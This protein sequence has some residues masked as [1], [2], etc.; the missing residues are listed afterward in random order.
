MA[1]PKGGL[2]RGLSSLLPDYEDY[3]E[4]SAEKTGE[5]VQELK[6]EDIMPNPDQPRKH[7]DEDK[8]TDLAESIKEN[9]VLQP[10]LVVPRENGKYMIVAGERRWRAS[11]MAGKETI[12]A[13]IKDASLQ[14]VLELALIENVQRDDLSPIEEA[15]AYSL[16]MS[17]FDYTQEKLSQRMGKSRSAIANSTRLLDLPDDVL[18]MVEDGKLT[19]GHV[20]PLLGINVPEWQSFIAHEVYQAN[21]TVREVEE[22]VQKAQK[23]GFVK[24][25][26]EEVLFQTKPRAKKL[27]NELRILQDQLAEQLSTRVTIKRTGEKGKLVIDYANEEDLKRIIDALHG[28]IY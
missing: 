5:M 15:R 23:D 6:I 7:F 28:N 12:P 2:G 17:M 14:Q 24:Y 21:K 20:R 13:L 8:L 3:I 1:K 16:L 9:G 26:T 4:K 11:K 25:S 10:I 19:V 27:P 18:E 22:L